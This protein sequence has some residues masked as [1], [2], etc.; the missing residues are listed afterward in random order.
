MSNPEEIQAALP[1]TLAEN[2]ARERIEP[3]E[4][5]SEDAARDPIKKPEEAAAPEAQLAEALKTA[6]AAET[7]TVPAGH[8]VVLPATLELAEK[9]LAAY[10]GQKLDAKL[11]DGLNLELTNAMPS[12]WKET[13][14]NIVLKGPMVGPN[15]ALIGEELIGALKAHPGAHA[16]IE[17]LTAKDAAGNPLLPFGAHQDVDDKGHVAFRM[18][19]EHLTHEDYAQLVQALASGQAQA[20]KAHKEEADVEVHAA[21]P[22]GPEEP[23]IKTPEIKGPEIKPYPTVPAAEVPQAQVE[24]PVINM[25]RAAQE[26]E[27]GHGQV[28]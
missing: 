28:A 6:P 11:L 19:I 13:N 8:T 16:V 27:H 2:A 23:P 1:D 15:F 17:K 4:Q 5:K 21:S 20:P 12:D 9:N 14:F 25:G 10:L 3:P 26:Q 24:T 7:K 18:S 22:N